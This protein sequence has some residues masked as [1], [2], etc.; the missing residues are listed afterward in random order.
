MS[1]YV[2]VGLVN[3]DQTSCSKNMILTSLVILT[4]NIYGIREKQVMA[5]KRTRLFVQARTTIAAILRFNYNMPLMR[6]GKIMDKDHST[7]IHMLKNHR[8]DMEYDLEYKKKYEQI[9]KLHSC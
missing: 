8:Q 6:I 5:K 7:I 3:Y 1:P 2:F 9:K 4:A